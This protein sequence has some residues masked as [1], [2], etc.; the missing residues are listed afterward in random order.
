MKL[1]KNFLIV[2]GTGAFCS[3]IPFGY[4]G[5]FFGFPAY[6][7]AAVAITLIFRKELGVVNE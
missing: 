6:T 4:I 7:L 3:L 1:F 2:W 5:L